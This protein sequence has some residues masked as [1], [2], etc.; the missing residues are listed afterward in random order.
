ML[1]VPL[2]QLLRKLVLE[3]SQ[4][5]LYSADVRIFFWRIDSISIAERCKTAE[6]SVFLGQRKGGFK[7]PSPS[8]LQ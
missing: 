5:A 2:V 6:I 8:C 7:V 1:D 3:T 4:V